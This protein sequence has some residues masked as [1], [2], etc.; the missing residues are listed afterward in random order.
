ML[1]GAVQDVVELRNGVAA[2]DTDGHGQRSGGWS[3]EVVS[4]H[5]CRRCD[6]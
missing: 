2:F 1:L 6:D 5:F 4:C 3:A